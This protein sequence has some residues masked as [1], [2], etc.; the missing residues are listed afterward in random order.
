MTQEL[1]PPPPTEGEQLPQMIAVPLKAIKTIA[2][3]YNENRG[4][5]GMMARM[6]RQKIPPELDQFFKEVESDDPN[7]AQ[8]LE[9]MATGEQDAYNITPGEIPQP[10]IGERVFTRDDALVAWRMHYKQGLGYRDIAKYF[11]EELGCPVSH[12]TVSNY[13]GEIDEEH[14]EEEAHSHDTAKTIGKVAAFIVAA[15]AAGLV[16]GHFFL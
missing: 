11:T 5:V 1:P 16:L 3:L 6:A 13:I 10:S 14:E 15:V 7:A 2:K 4:M 12:S 9:R 8:R